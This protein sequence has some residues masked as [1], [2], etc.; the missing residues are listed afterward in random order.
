M[1]PKKFTTLL[2]EARE[3][4][5]SYLHRTCLS[6]VKNAAVRNI[7]EE[8]VPSIVAEVE[9]EFGAPCANWNDRQLRDVNRTL[10]LRMQAYLGDV[11]RR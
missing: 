11:K 10:P 7:P 5:D 9:K 2:G 8:E 6:F 4:E 3:G 1:P